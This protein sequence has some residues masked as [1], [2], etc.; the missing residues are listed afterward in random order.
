MAMDRKADVTDAEDSPL[1]TAEAI[2][3]EAGD[4]FTCQR[5][6]CSI[7]LKQPSRLRPHQLK[8][9]ICQCGSKMDGPE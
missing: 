1:T 7:D 6:G 2:A 9:F 5:C 8:P 3:P 4:T